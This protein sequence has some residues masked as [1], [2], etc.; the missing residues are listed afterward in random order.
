MIRA[1]LIVSALLA[2]PFLA[3]PQLADGEAAGAGE[4]CGASW[5]G[6]L[7]CMAGRACIC[8]TERGGQLTGRPGGFRWD[9]GVLRPDCAPAPAGAAP[10]DLP[11]GLLPGVAPDVASDIAPW[12]EPRRS[13]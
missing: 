7:A 3:V 8:R 4:R 11:P 12:A 9:C 13:R 10:V 1:A 5:E 6:L 2:A